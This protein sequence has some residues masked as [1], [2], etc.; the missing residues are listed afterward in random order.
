MTAIMVD[1]GRRIV[2]SSDRALEAARAFV[3]YIEYFQTHGTGSLMCRYPD[4]D[5][6]GGYDNIVRRSQELAAEI[7]S[8]DGRSSKRS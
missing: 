6:F 7:D 2:C 3:A 5:A 4:D 8:F 1:T